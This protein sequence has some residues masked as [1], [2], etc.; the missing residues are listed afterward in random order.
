[1]SKQ[2]RGMFR[3]IATAI[4]GF[5]GM[6]EPATH[7]YPDPIIGAPASDNFRHGNTR[8]RGQAGK[9]RLSPPPCTPGTITFHDKCVRYYGRKRADLIGRN[10]QHKNDMGM[11]DRM[12]RVPTEAD[13]AALKPWA[14]RA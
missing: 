13:F 6:R 5:V 12:D 2:K 10:I 11:H 9:K 8:F 1:M 3:L 14:W 4:M 7:H